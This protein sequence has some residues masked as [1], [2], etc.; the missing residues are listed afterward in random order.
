MA[1]KFYIEP[2]AGLFETIIRR[3]HKEERILV[4]RRIIIFSAT[5][6]VSAIGFF[7]AYKMFLSD[8][9]SLGFFNFFS[10]IFSDFSA[11]MNNWPSFAMV[12]LQTLPVASLALCLFALL[13]FLQSVKSIFINY[14]KYIAIRSI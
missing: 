1:Q 2:P 6:L 4:L 9:N 8:S 3:I 11:V 12:L 13:L 5:F 10:L 7:P 14:E